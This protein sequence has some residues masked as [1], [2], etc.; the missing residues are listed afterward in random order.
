M[1]NINID[2][3]TQRGREEVSS[4][5]EATLQKQ[6]RCPT[7]DFFYSLIVSDVLPLTAEV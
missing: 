7:A 1:W 5:E 4:W 3:Y 6:E 2:P